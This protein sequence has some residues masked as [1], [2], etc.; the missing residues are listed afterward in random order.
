VPFLFA[1]IK[2]N[3][4]LLLSVRYLSGQEIISLKKNDKFHDTINF[5]YFFKVLI[6]FIYLHVRDERLMTEDDFYGRWQTKHA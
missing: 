2:S 1:F 6:L 3:N 5:S 4:L